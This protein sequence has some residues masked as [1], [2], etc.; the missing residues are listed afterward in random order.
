MKNVK[1]V[2]IYL[3]AGK[4]QFYILKRYLIWQ[5]GNH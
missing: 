1:Y 3:V 2:G 4:G 5:K